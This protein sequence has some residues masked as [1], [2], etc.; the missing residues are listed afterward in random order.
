MKK[1][2]IIVYLNVRWFSSLWFSLCFPS[3]ALSGVNFWVH[4]D[5]PVHSP[6][7]YT[8]HACQM[9]AVFYPEEG[10]NCPIVE[11]Q[12]DGTESWVLSFTLFSCELLHPHKSHGSRTSGVNRISF[13][14]PPIPV[15]INTPERSFCWNIWNDHRWNIDCICHKTE[16]RLG[17]WEA[18]VLPWNFIMAVTAYSLGVWLTQET[19]PDIMAVKLLVAIWR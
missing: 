6:V 16:Y 8:V 7:L 18:D 3:V 11:T 9:F 5:S 2:D 1:Q 4:L 19:M 10:K 17:T 15:Q 13:E 12:K 14:S